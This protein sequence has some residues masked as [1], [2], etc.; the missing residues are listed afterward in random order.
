MIFTCLVRDEKQPPAQPMWKQE[1]RTPGELLN[2]LR[3]TRRN[4][5][6]PAAGTT[7]WNMAKDELTIS[8]VIELK[9]RN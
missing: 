5:P 1:I 6:S 7:D 9:R 3:K 2:V 8:S 4:G